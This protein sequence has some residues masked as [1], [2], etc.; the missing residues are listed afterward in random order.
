[1]AMPGRG[2]VGRERGPAA[3]RVHVGGAG[4]RG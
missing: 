1:M 3:G 4:M 2:P